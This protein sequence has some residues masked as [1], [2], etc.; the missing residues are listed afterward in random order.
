MLVLELEPA[1]D[2][3]VVTELLDSAAVVV[4][5]AP[6]LEPSLL[7]DE[8]PLPDE[9]PPPQPSAV[10]TT[11]GIQRCLRTAAALTGPTSAAPSPRPRAPSSSDRSR[12]W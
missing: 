3:P 10:A 1:S 9:P 4:V 2:E 12:R 5:S 7:L 8:P 11:R 6:P